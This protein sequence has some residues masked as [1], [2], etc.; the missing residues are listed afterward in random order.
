MKYTAIIRDAE[1]GNEIARFETVE[2]ARAELQKYE[3]QDKADGSYEEGF[4]E[5]YELEDLSGASFTV[6]G[7]LSDKLNKGLVDYLADG[8]IERDGEKIPC[9]IGFVAMD[10]LIEAT[11][12]FIK[13]GITENGTHYYAE[14]IEI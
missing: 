2:E 8:Y 13:D 12:I 4:Y 6:T 11:H 10:S 7:E 5:I 14:T 1:A 9:Q 3:E